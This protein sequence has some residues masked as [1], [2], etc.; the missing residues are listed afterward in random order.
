MEPRLAKCLLI[1]TQ[2]K[3]SEEAII[4]AS[5]LSAENIFIYPP[6]R[7]EEAKVA[8]QK[9]H[10]SEGDFISMLNVFRKSLPLDVT[11]V[12]YTVMSP[13]FVPAKKRRLRMKDSLI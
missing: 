9:F 10:S 12:Y 4:I 5:L 13:L 2:L 8:H 1:A 11:K 3:C 7:R 6:N